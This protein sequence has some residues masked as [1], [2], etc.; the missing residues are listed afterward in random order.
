MNLYRKCRAKF[1]ATE[2]SDALAVVYGGLPALHGDGLHWAVMPALFAGNAFILAE[3]RI[4][5]E[6]V[7]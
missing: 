3:N 4:R 5:R 6:K 2:A 1:L 7:I